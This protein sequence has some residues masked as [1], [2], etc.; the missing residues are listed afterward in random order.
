MFQITIEIF[1]VECDFV[2]QGSRDNMSIVLVL[3]QNAPKVSQ[4]AIDREAKLDE[5]LETK[6][7]GLFYFVA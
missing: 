1:T 4:E 3:L 5:Q 6:T 7:K 2:L